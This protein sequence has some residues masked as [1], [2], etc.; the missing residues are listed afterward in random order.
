MKESKLQNRFKA[1]FGL[2]PS[3]VHSQEMT[4]SKRISFGVMFFVVWVPLF[5]LLTALSSDR[6]FV[7]ALPSAVIGGLVA[8]GLTV[9]IL[10]WFVQRSGRS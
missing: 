2:D 10:P 6:T 4:M 8:A 5:A 1:H 3:E 7:D 9:V